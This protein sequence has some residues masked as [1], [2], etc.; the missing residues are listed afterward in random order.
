MALENHPV[1]HRATCLSSLGL[2]RAF[3]SHIVLKSIPEKIES[4]IVGYDM[5][6]EQQCIE[7]RALKAR[8]STVI[9]RVPARNRLFYR[10]NQIRCEIHN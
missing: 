5:M 7:C 2:S 9:S 1:V 10:P 4:K 8:L 3:T 6:I